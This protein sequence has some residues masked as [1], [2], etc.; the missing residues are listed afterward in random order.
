MK[1]AEISLVNGTTEN[2]DMDTVT[3]NE[4]DRYVQIMTE[5]E[6]VLIPFESIV[7]LTIHND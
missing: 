5:E 4:A 6:Q 3:I 1:T 2:A 7:I